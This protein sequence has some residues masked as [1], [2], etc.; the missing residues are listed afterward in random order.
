M[1]TI[2]AV[3]VT[4][5]LIVTALLAASVAFARTPTP[6]A[7][8]T[9][10]PWPSPTLGPTTTPT[11]P[12]GQVARFSGQVWEDAFGGYWSAGDVTAKIG[13]IVCGREARYCEPPCVS[14][15]PVDPP[16]VTLTYQMDVFPAE[17]KQGCGYEGA[18]VTF[19][20]G[21]SQAKQTAVWHAGT[22]QEVNLSMDPPA[23]YFYGNAMI[24]AAI[25]LPVGYHYPEVNAYVNGNLCGRDTGFVWSELDYDVIVKSAEE[26]PG[27]GVEGAPITFKLR[28][29]REN[30][31]GVA[32][33]KG[34]W[35]AWGEG[36]TGQ[37]LNLTMDPAGIALANVGDGSSGDR[38]TKPWI[39]LPLSLAALGLLG[40]A[41]AA[42]LQRSR[43]DW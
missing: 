18:P 33:E 35:H 12:P 14:H 22:S 1:K 32:R 29:D 8:P 42:V 11:L 43:S 3:T 28:D 20:V 37:E 17:L 38:D 36:N 6:T 40:I 27:C 30:I 16:P 10:T 24:P 21:D 26:Q 2:V 34:V 19:F 4:L 15:F 13:D 31:I 39:A 7:T 41:T 9:A 23:A 25:S 5:S